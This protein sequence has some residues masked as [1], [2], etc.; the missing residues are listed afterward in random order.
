VFEKPQSI[1]VSLD[2]VVNDMYT[3]IFNVSVSLAF[4]SGQSDAANLVL[5][6]SNGDESFGW[7][8]APTSKGAVYSKPL[9]MLPTNIVKAEMEIFIS[10][11]ARD[12]FWY[13][14]LPDDIA[15]PL[16]SYPGGTY[17][18]CQVFIDDKLVYIDAIFPTIYTG[19]MNPLLWRPIV[20]IGA[21][22][23]PSIKF[24]LTPYLSLLFSG[25]S[26][27]IGMN[28]SSSA[29]SFWFVDG[30][31]LIWTEG[32]PDY[33]TPFVGDLK[34]LRNN[35]E[36]PTEIVYGD[37]N[38]I[39]EVN[40]KAT[41]SI[42]ASGKH[43]IGKTCYT[44]SFHKSI[45]FDNQLIYFDGGNR[46]FADQST[47]MNKASTMFTTKG[48]VFSSGIANNQYKN[49]PFKADIRSTSYFNGSYRFDTEIDHG[50]DVIES[51]VSTGRFM[52]IQALKFGAAHRTLETRQR[53]TGFF[54]DFVRGFGS[55]KQVYK[56]NSKG[57]CYARNVS[58]LKST[59]E[60]DFIDNAC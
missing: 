33:E 27:V 41:R 24:D 36:Q 25:T 23:V 47:S 17:K 18:E 52:P 6:L 21:F 5:P 57:N 31:L 35:L 28:V 13:F 1:V 29:N 42:T 10:G 14:N 49:F 22:D 37:V 59:I 51:S 19:G 44:T 46:T 15:E 40:T 54:S 4:Y 43:C 12:E 9:P 30:N 32:R 39:L 60:Y 38:K 26:P 50:L 53:S 3:G 7:F 45:S 48:G 34:F 16:S 58:S 11:H 55:T 8:T 2:N 56:L 20:G